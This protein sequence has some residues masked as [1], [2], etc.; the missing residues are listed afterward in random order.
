MRRWV[1]VSS[2]APPSSITISS[3][4]WN[5]ITH[6]TSTPVTVA[7]SATHCLA[8]FIC[9]NN[10]SVA[11]HIVSDNIDGTTGWNVIRGADTFTGKASMWYKFNIPAG[12]TTITCTGGTSTVDTVGIVHEITGVTA[13]TGGESNSSVSSGSNNPQTGT[14]TNA[15][16]VSIYIAGLANMSTGVTTM[17]LNGTGTTGVWAYADAVHSLQNAAGVVTC[18]SVPYLIVSSSAARGHGW[19]LTAFPTSADVVIAL[20]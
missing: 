8:V 15:T 14:V 13:F 12:I 5:N 7:P 18:A 2:A 3:T 20:H 9:G 10:G 11:N 4:A 6:G 17:T 16:P 1:P 19:T